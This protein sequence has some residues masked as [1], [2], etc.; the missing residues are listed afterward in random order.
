M[1][2][3][4]P[5]F[6]LVDALSDCPASD[7]A[8]EAP[9]L[10]PA[11]TRSTTRKIALSPQL[12]DADS[13]LCSSGRPAALFGGRPE[14]FSLRAHFSLPFTSGRDSPIPKGLSRIG[15]RSFVARIAS[16]GH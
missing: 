4:S 9:K 14:G 12:F 11:S 2:N 13:E 6:A 8:T 7:G 16:D 1:K 3:R 10:N 5:L 15:M